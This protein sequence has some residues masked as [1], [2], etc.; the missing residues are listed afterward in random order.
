MS[1]ARGWNI[2]PRARAKDARLTNA[3]DFARCRLKMTPPAIAVRRH[4]AE[5]RRD[6]DAKAR[7]GGGAATATAAAATAA[8]GFPFAM[9]G[10]AMMMAAFGPNVEG[11]RRQAA[12]M[13]GGMT[14]GGG[15]APMIF[16]P[17]PFK[18]VRDD[19]DGGD[20]PAAR[21]VRRFAAGLMTRRKTRRARAMGAIER[22]R[23]SMA[24]TSRAASA[25]RL[26]KRRRAREEDW[27]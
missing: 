11:L 19:A 5:M 20:G 25:W 18:S 26:G 10:N 13:K 16:A 21:R 15:A 9:P 24:K 1:N 14:D 17:M 23:T 27:R 6:G 7:E 3:C 2:H 12:V 4:A 8:G 22:R